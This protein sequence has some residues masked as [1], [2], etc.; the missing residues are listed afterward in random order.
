[1][2][3]AF[4][5]VVLNGADLLPLAEVLPNHTKIILVTHN[6]ESDIIEGQVARL[7]LPA[8]VKR[9]LGAEVDKT[10][11]M[12]IAGAASVSAIVAIS[13]EDAR[14]YRD[15]VP[16]TPVLTLSGVFDYP[17]F[18]GPRP[19]VS[20]RLKLGYLAKM[21]WWPNREG[22]E[23]FLGS[24]LPELDEREVEAHFFGP[25]SEA[26]AGRHPALHAHGFVDSLE[27]VWCETGIAICPILGGSGLNIKLVEALYNGIPVLAT[28]RA[29]RG[30]PPL[31]DPALAIVEPEDWAAY[32]RSPRARELA[33]AT[34]KPE[35]RRTFAA[36]A[37]A[38]RLADAL[39]EAMEPRAEMASG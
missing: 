8:A 15:Q 7:R 24:V 21:S 18:Q 28:P 4:D 35:T 5:V 22:A 34:V 38:R 13:E 6:V 25:G 1:M 11:R 12:E 26:F 36:D 10:R 17:P 3:G 29:C 19:P 27:S 39:G 23:W 31:D 20:P 2:N 16:G 14:W 32:L 30:L 33:A 37:Q 9:A